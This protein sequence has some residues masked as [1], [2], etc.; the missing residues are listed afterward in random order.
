MK[1]NLRNGHHSERIIHPHL[2]ILPPE[3]L[4]IH[5]G[6]GG[7]AMGGLLATSVPVGRIVPI[8]AVFLILEHIMGNQDTLLL[9]SS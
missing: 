4:P 7:A 1:L 9:A 3:L 6:S 8:G 2:A 5:G